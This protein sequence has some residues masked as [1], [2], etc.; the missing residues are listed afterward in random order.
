M[1]SNLA[2]R[3]AKLGR[4]KKKSTTTK[5]G[6]ATTSTSRSN[7]ALPPSKQ[8]QQ[9]N[10]S[11][12]SRK[13]QSSNNNNGGLSFQLPQ[14]PRFQQGHRNALFEQVAPSFNMS[15]PT[16]TVS[17]H[18]SNVSHQ[19]GACFEPPMSQLTC[20]QFTHESSGT[21][22]SSSS[23][24]NNSS[25]G[26]E[27]HQYSASS[28][29]N[30]STA[31]RSSSS[32]FST[33]QGRS[34][35][36]MAT[37]QPSRFEQEQNSNSNIMMNPPD[38]PTTSATPRR[39]TWM[40][41]MATSGAASVLSKSISRGV[42]QQDA[43]PPPPSAKRS[44]VP[45]Q[46]PGNSETSAN[47]MHDAHVETNTHD[48]NENQSNEQPNSLITDHFKVVGSNKFQ[49]DDDDKKQDADAAFA[50]R[51]E[52]LA[53]KQKDLET[54]F[55]QKQQGFQALATDIETK[56]Q[57]LQ[58]LA[59]EIET[60]MQG[61]DDKVEQE[62]TSALARL[63]AAAS[64]GVAKITLGVDSFNKLVSSA[65]ESFQSLI[66]QPM[67]Q[68]LLPSAMTSQR[69][70]DS[71][72]QSSQES[73]SMPSQVLPVPSTVHVTT[74]TT[75]KRSASAGKKKNA[76]KTKGAASTRAKKRVE[77]KAVRQETRTSNRLKKKSKGLSATTPKRAVTRTSKTSC[78]TPST[79]A[80]SSRV[81]PVSIT[82]TRRATTKKRLGATTAEATLRTTRKRSASNESA[83][84]Q[85]R[86]GKNARK[87][88]S[89]KGL[90]SPAVSDSQSSSDSGFISPVLNRRKH[91]TK[92]RRTYGGR[93]SGK[94]VAVGIACLNDSFD[95]LSQES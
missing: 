21:A 35:F 64:D 77:P 74:K 60:K 9:R 37:G 27:L 11:A 72:N 8:Q 69:N 33:G 7:A 73:S 20:S 80:A 54:L 92:T 13:Q 53:E 61:F 63:N 95:F 25:I 47:T 65:K 79:K 76:T 36:S 59:A 46:P 22:D 44:L 86:G 50:E 70:E 45:L 34:L 67:A 88:T 52:R 28:S 6:A 83:V 75:T 49:D 90:P 29:S 5:N 30:S 39:R 10:S 40:G 78:V 12:P 42:Q 38:A 2:A 87:T 17:F 89:T 85:K 15:Q 16:S 91:S 23:H 57:D 4:K 81:V 18:S 94:K 48:L 58:K 26:P 56:Q 55:E 3:A 1:A 51:E 14:K 68:K 43:P 71:E 93:G 19:E 82:I 84:Q 66:L 24:H 41:L 62:T 32:V 31:L